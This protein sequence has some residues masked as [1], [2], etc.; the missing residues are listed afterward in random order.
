MVYRERDRLW[1][2]WDVVVRSMWFIVWLT[3]PWRT[4][5]EVRAV[6]K[7]EPQPQWLTCR[8]QCGVETVHEV[9]YW[10]IEQA[11]TYWCTECGHHEE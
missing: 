10:P 3:E 1:F 5:S 6:R 2:L 8:G 11:T 7:E 9:A 4:R